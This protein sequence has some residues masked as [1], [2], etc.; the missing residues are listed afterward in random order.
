MTMKIIQ[1]PLQDERQE[2]PEP[3]NTAQSARYPFEYAFWA[4]VS[5]FVGV[6]VFLVGIWYLFHVSLNVLD[7]IVIPLLVAGGCLAI[8]GFLLMLRA[9][10]NVFGSIFELFGLRLGEK[11]TEEK[12][13][14]AEPTVDIGSR[15]QLALYIMVT[16][17]YFLGEDG[18]RRESRIPP[19]MWALANEILLNPHVGLR[20]GVGKGQR[21]IEMPPENTGD[22]FQILAAI[23]IGETGHNYSIE[24]QSGTMVFTFSGKTPASMPQGKTKKPKK[25]PTKKGEVQEPKK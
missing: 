11:S 10:S 4:S 23:S 12:E 16:D 20:V 18:T 9:A 21:F 17:H 24:T 6:L 7:F 14:S 5:I 13:Q 15:I 25:P 22:I 8:Y 19:V 3:K 2:R 1:T